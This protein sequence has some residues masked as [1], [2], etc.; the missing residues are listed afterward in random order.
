MAS[1]T[2]ARLENGNRVTGPCVS[3]DSAEALTRGVHIIKPEFQASQGPWAHYQEPNWVDPIVVHRLLQAQQLS[4]AQGFLT[5]LGA[6][7]GANENLLTFRNFVAHRGRATALKVRKL[8][9]S[10]GLMSAADP[11]ELPFYRAPK[12]PISIF[13]TWI[14]ELR[15]IVRI[16]AEIRIACGVCDGLPRMVQRGDRGE[17]S[18][19]E[20]CERWQVRRPEFRSPW[21]AS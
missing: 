13:T 14:V 18:V 16:A 6:G 20:N 1:A 9:R 19:S 3:R 2:G 4:N 5:A 17:S 11:I 8:V 12:R 10:A 15:S 7:T 21:R